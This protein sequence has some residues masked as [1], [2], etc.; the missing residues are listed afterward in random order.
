MIEA[1][2]QQRASSLTEETENKDLGERSQKLPRRKSPV[3]DISPAL[4]SNSLEEEITESPKSEMI[5]P[6]SLRRRN[7]AVLVS[8]STEESSMKEDLTVVSPRS[9]R[10][11]SQVE[12]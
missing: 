1:E 2:G 10:R 3:N 4:D 6:R 12:E 11:R 9:L 5:K 7:S 8:K